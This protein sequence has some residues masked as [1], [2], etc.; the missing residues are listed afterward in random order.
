MSQIL[1]KSL[2]A[3]EA[4]PAP[5]PAPRMKSRPPRSRT[6]ARASA[7]ASMASASSASEIAA[8]SCRYWAAK[9]PS[10]GTSVRTWRG[11]YTSG[12]PR[13]RRPALARAATVA[14]AATSP[15]PERI[16]AAATARRAGRLDSDAAGRGRGHL[17]DGE[18]APVPPHHPRP[19]EPAD[20][21]GV[22]DVGG[23]HPGRGRIED[24]AIASHPLGA[25]GQNARG[26]GHRGGRQVAVVAHGVPGG[27][28]VRRRRDEVTCAS[29]P[30]RRPCLVEGE[31]RS[32][33]DDGHRHGHDGA[34]TGEAA[35]GDAGP[36]SP[37][38][39]PAG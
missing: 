9:A 15:R 14:S 5:P 34:G 39:R 21:L 33:G 2:T 27:G 19:A 37:R 6:S 26:P 23:I 28:D 7:I 20:Q 4:W 17:E 12:A 36:G 10:A 18:A 31:C 35:R 3:W 24:E 8:A 1:R 32:G 38:P 22:D 30:L 16:L 11:T 25:R 29:V 13:S